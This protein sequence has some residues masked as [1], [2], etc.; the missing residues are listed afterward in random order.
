MASKFHVNPE[1]E[2]AECHATKRPCLYGGEESH[3]F[4]EAEARAKYEEKMKTKG[5]AK[6]SKTPRKRKNGFTPTANPEL[7]EAMRK[8][9]R[10]SAAAPHDTRPGR[11][12]TR[13]DAKKAAIREQK[14]S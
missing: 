14:D 11:E 9:G 6:F 8:L 7:A 12:R 1:G 4:S 3:G 10:S 5:Q 2:V 13:K